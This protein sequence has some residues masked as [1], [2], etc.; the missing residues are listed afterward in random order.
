MNNEQIEEIASQWLA[1]QLSGE[2]TEAD[3]NELDAW[4]DA[5]TLNRVAYLRLAAAWKRLASLTALGANVSSGVIPAR[6]AWGDAF[7][8]KIA[9]P[10][11]VPP[12]LGDNLENSEP[13]V[14]ADPER[15]PLSETAAFRGRVPRRL[16]A[17]AAALLVVLGGA[18]PYLR[19]LWN[20]DRYST[21]VGG[22]S[23]VHLSEGSEIT[24]NTDTKLRVDMTPA[25]RRIVLD[26][27]E[28]FF[29]VAHDA[30]HPF[31]VY[32]G[33]KRAIALGTQF[34]VKLERDDVRVVVTEGSV[35]LATTA[36][37]SP[38]GVTAATNDPHITVIRAGSVAHTENTTVLV[39]PETATSGEELLSWRK[40]YLV[41]KDATLADAVSEFNRYNT[42][43]MIIGDPGITGMRIGGNFRADNVAAF[44]WLLESG[45]PIRI[46]QDEDKIILK[47]R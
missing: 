45:F 23:V 10:D 42:R 17:A 3:Q 11:A 21:P 19:H 12:S 41:F 24:L 18:Y 31:V 44:L 6:G 14:S 13:A 26:Q 32:A 30:S 29:V 1:K 28:A 8:S 38:S 47:A 33:T 25:Q 36:V 46:I 34:A 20:E 15:R 40:G 2:W 35:G 9:G 22:L 4:L 16:F 5:T 7:F 37:P 43:K 39:D 27:G